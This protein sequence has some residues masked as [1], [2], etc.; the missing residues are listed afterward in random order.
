MYRSKSNANITSDSSSN[1]LDDPYRSYF[2]TKQIAKTLEITNN[3]RIIAFPSVPSKNGKI[4]WYKIGGNSAYFYKY[5]VAPRL[6]K[7]PPTIHPDTDLNHRFKDGVIAINNHQAFIDNL[8]KL[9]YEYRLESGLI[10]FNLNHAF[11]VNEIKSLKDREHE[12]KARLN[13]L[14]RPQNSKPEIYRLIIELSRTVPTKAKNL[15]RGFHEDFAPELNHAVI[16]LCKV[17][18]RYANGRINTL[19]AKTLLLGFL[20]DLTAVLSIL[21]EN[22]CLSIAD[23]IRLGKLTSDLKNNINRSFDGK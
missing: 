11:S 16:E 2:T 6:N 9:G 3:S 22:N 5:I 4:E 14:F 20:D 12:D 1:N 8:A 7:K 13:Q 17:Y 15:K 19:N 23:Q 21:S 18:H 10:I